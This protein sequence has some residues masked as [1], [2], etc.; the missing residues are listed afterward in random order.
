MEEAGVKE[1]SG[2]EVT[3]KIIQEMTT[4]AIL[5]QETVD[6][7]ETVVPEVIVRDLHLMIDHTHAQN[8]IEAKVQ[9][10]VE[11]T[12]D[13]DLPQDSYKAVVGKHTHPTLLT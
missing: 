4:I 6:T 11:A 10:T 3:T 9:T 8:T 5:D 2:A 13:T 1:T 12:G 7:I